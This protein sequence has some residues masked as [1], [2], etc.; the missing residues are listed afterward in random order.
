MKIL[1]SNLLLL[2]SF[3][4][5]ARPWDNFNLPY[6]FGVTEFNYE[7][8]SKG[9]TLDLT[10]G[11][12]S[13]WY[14]PTKSGSLTAVSNNT[15]QSPLDKWTRAS[16]GQTGLNDQVDSI[17]KKHDAPWSGLCHGFSATSIN[18][19][20]PTTKRVGDTLF[21]SSEIKGILAAYYDYLVDH[22]LIETNFIG[23]T[24]F[25]QI[26][27]TL[28][29]GD[30]TSP[31]CDDVNPG[32]FH[33]ALHQRLAVEKKGFVLDLDR[34]TPIWNVPVIGYKSKY[35]GEYNYWYPFKDYRTTRTI[36]VE[37]TIIYLDYQKPNQDTSVRGKAGQI[38]SS[39]TYNYTL[40]LDPHGN[41]VGGEWIT[42][43]HP[44]FIWYAPKFPRPSGD[45]EFLNQLVNFES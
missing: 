25:M 31:Q 7:K 42:F 8:L 45:W 29:V 38:L 18:F 34:E 4:L 27:R 43:P 32:A 41:I 13:G 10:N 35:I 23:S 11:P 26:N 37:T 39:R 16:N 22:N 2:T 1:I 30:S 6:N 24:C 33:L 3:S 36:E 5:F 28:N 20:E 15:N 12:W 40:E 9:H 44:D 14:W 17:L 21:T 19:E